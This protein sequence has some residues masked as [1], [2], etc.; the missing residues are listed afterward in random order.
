MTFS[1]TSPCR[2]AAIL[3]CVI[4][5]TVAFSYHAHQLRP[6][7]L[8]GLMTQHDPPGH[9]QHRNP[10]FSVPPPSSAKTE[11]LQQQQQRNLIGVPSTPGWRRGQLDKLVSWA[12]NDQA[13]RPI[14]R[15]YEPDSLWLWARWTGTVLS[16]VWLPI[17]VNM[18]IGVVVDIEVHHFAESSWPL[19]SVPPADDPLIQQLAGL[20]A[21]WEYQVT[22]STF[23]LTFFTAEA[24]KHWRQVY[25]TTRAIQG[26]IN[27]ICMLIT[28]SAPPGDAAAEELVHRCTRLLRKGH[29]FF[30]AATPTVS[31]GL[32]DEDDVDHRMY[33]VQEEEIGPMLLSAEGLRGLAQ[34]GELT[35]EEADALLSSGLPPTQY[36]YVLLEWVGLYFMEGLELEIIGH[37]NGQPNTGL[38]ENVLRQLSML[39]GEY[40]NI[41][42]M[43]S[44]RM[45]LAYVQ[46]VQ[47]LVDVLV[48]LAPFSLYSDMGS[49]S[50]P[51]TGLLTLFFKGLLELSK[52]FLDPFGVEGYPAQNI[53]VDVLVSELNFGAASRWVTAAKIL[54]ESPYSKKS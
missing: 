15:E 30:W 4:G 2:P 13:N 43:C 36:T 34:A 14:I 24:Y 19:L 5:G 50:V 40:F 42:D 17:L 38:E 51:L 53:R 26:R 44:G 32:A 7:R 27:D 23:I 47:V 9:R 33:N 12:V 6:L 10:L 11:P 46:F 35:K 37:K 41:G 20:N 48:A 18:A 28:M 22:F 3:F 1:S 29:S 25:F 52:S 21:A 45:S 54:P 31:D 39:R 8:P 49:L 16:L